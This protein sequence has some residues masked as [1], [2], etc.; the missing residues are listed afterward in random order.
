M[1]IKP[2]HERKYDFPFNRKTY[3]NLENMLVNSTQELIT[4]QQAKVIVGQLKAQY[5][6]WKNKKANLVF[7]IQ[8]Y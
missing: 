2:P 5:R 3:K 1:K 4:R 6:R 7:Q 8:G